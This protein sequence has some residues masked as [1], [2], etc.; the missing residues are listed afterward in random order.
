MK[1][2]RCNRDCPRK[3][4]PYCSTARD[5]AAVFRW[6]FPT[7]MSR[8]ARIVPRTNAVLGLAAASA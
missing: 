8:Q 4:A 3:S 6:P 5:P 2:K 7:A 1:Y